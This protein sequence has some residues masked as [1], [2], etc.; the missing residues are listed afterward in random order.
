MHRAI[1]LPPGSG[2]GRT[3]GPNGYQLTLAGLVL[4]V[5]AH[6]AFNAVAAATLWA[7]GHPMLALGMLVSACAFD[8]ALQAML[9]RWA[10]QAESTPESRGFRQLAVLSAVRIAVYMTPPFIAASGGG[11][12]ELLFFGLQLCGMG[13]IALSASAMSRLIFWGFLS[14]ALLA[15]AVL[16]IILLPP[17]IAAAVV[18]SLVSLTVVMALIS[19]GTSRAIQTWRAAF[20]TNVAMMNDL[21][22]ARDEA[23]RAQSAASAFLATMSHEIRTP[24]NGVLGMAQLL[25][26]DET[27]PRQAQ[28]IDTL[29]D[30][31]K[32]LMGI[33]ND[34][35]D[36]SKIDAGHMEIVRGAEDLQLFLD[37]LVGFWGGRAQEKGVRLG[38]QVQEGLPEFVLVDALRLRQVLFNLMGNALK[39][40]EQGAV[41]VLVAAEPYGQGAVWL[42]ISVRDTGPG[43]RPEKLARLFHRFTQL[44]ETDARSGGT[45]LG[46]AI[47]RQLTELMGGRI[48]A[49]S[50]PGE[51]SVFHVELPVE[52]AT[53]PRAVEPEAEADAPAGALMVLAVDDNPVNL[54]VIGQLL[55]S[56]GHEVVRAASGREALDLLGQQ[57]FDLV[58]MDIQ[59]PGMTGIEAVQALRG[60]D[61][62]NRQAP[63]IALTADVTS[64]GRQ[65]Y[66]DLGFTDHASK[67]IQVE[68][69]FEVVVRALSAGS[70]EAAESVAV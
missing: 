4:P 18:A 55:G 23:R 63:V 32:Y 46:L 52:I 5:W 56:F 19:A 44:D 36:I 67:P 6:Y 41:D 59:M 10:R 7:L 13:A 40:T 33:L 16:P 70:G 64:G 68:E 28:R 48:S 37:R 8:T 47:A 34:I 57:V 17:P 29:I 51:G 61:G 42:R 12:G 62:P 65:R 27:D 45:G 26:R 9:R 31:G 3:E 21:A 60:R 54:Q 14:P 20:D 30:S 2:D 66:I 24:M 43:I 69:L 50:T 25:K 35:L 49:E 38:L 1:N 15:A 22:E 11:A 53:R 39:F 58:L